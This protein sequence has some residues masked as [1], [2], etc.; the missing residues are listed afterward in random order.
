ML[1]LGVSFAIGWIF[2]VN[3]EIDQIANR[4]V[5]N[6]GD[7]ILALAAGSAG[8]LAFTRGVSAGVIG[9]MVAVALLPPLV[10]F[11]GG[12]RV[13]GAGCRGFPADDYQCLRA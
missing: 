7:V 8:V 12:S 11:I 3:P 4:T 5:V 2:G 1:A 6:F 13:L 10:V 9:V